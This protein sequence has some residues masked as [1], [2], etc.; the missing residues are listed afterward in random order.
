M[1]ASAKMC[2]RL[3]LSK[4]VCRVTWPGSHHRMLATCLF[5]WNNA[6]FENSYESSWFG[7]NNFNFRWW[8]CCLHPRT[9]SATVL[10]CL[11]S[12]ASKIW[13]WFRIFK[14]HWGKHHHDHCQEIPRTS[15]FIIR[16]HVH[17]ISKK[18]LCWTDRNWHPIFHYKRHKTTDW[19]EH[20]TSRKTSSWAPNRRLD[21]K[22][23]WAQQHHRLNDR[24]GKKASGNAH[25]KTQRN[26]K[27]QLHTHKIPN[28]IE[29]RWMNTSSIRSQLPMPPAEGLHI[30]YVT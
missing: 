23:A 18:H 27:R 11:R 21:W 29:K 24:I 25:K 17:R 4:N 22:G 14:I 8:D 10:F 2:E 15:S 19:I 30:A 12:L 28:W 13:F 1:I 26:R 6:N 20:T 16:C 5:H 7:N 9:F 3:C